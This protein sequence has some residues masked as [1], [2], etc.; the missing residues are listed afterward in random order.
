M[1]RFVQAFYAHGGDAGLINLDR[2]ASLKDRGGDRP[3]Y[4]VLDEDGEELGRIGHEDLARATGTV[5]P[6]QP[7][8]SVLWFHL[9]E[10][11]MVDAAREPI[12]AWVVGGGN[13]PEPITPAGTPG[14]RDTYC[15]ECP[16]GPWIFPYDRTLSTL[17]EAESYAGGELAER[18]ARNG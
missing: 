1:A 18:E 16:G 4:A 2:A 10:L 17:E 8:F 7:G 11:R 12:I 5:I 13:D 3:G 9:D 14:D 6:A 15:I